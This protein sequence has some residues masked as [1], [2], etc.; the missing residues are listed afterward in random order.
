MSNRTPNQE[1]IL[2]VHQLPPSPT[3]L[4]V[5]TWRR[6]QSLGAIAIKNSVY[7]LPFSDRA[8]EDFQW[9]KQ[10][11]EASGGEATVLRAA[12]VEG[13]TNREIVALFRSARDE[14]YAQVAADLD[15]LTGAIRE[16][17]KGGHLS[18]GR[19]NSH[20]A[21]LGRL[22]K[23]VE[24][25]IAT[26]FF[27]ASGRRAAM[28]AFERCNKALRAF[29]AR[30]EKGTKPGVATRASRDLALYQARCWFTRRNLFIDRLASIWLVRRFIDK[31][32]RFSYVA[33]GRAVKN[34][35]GFD[36]F[37]GEFTHLGDDCT[38]ETMLKQFGLI[39]H[40]G[41]RAIAEIVH[42]IDLKDNKFNRSEAAGVSTII[43]GLGQLLGS[44]QKLARQCIPIFDSLYELLGA[45]E[46]KAGSGE[47]NDR[48]TT[49]TRKTGNRKSR[50]SSRTKPG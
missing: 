14:D 24:R 4:R 12:A 46:N 39:E 23:Q 30:G 44:D 41:L 32:P 13:A 17:Q 42:D 36:L 21:E 50:R 45:T 29:Q 37:G 9:L 6:L 19:L 26:D 1:W 28:A 25:T 18:A 34:G 22:H 8:N 7:A 47:T 33:D 15:G 3:N 38:F 16:Q 35:I 40:R 11:I 48:T 31:K 27:D 2:M 49:P 5:R 10:E 43:R 20:E